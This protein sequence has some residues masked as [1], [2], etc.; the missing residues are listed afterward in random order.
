MSPN[1]LHVVGERFTGFASENPEVITLPEL[2]RLL[3]EQGLPGDTTLIVGQG[4]PDERLRRLQ[5]HLERLPERMR[6][7]LVADP[8]A[9]SR[10]EARLVHKRS[11]HNIMI[12]APEQV[13]EG[14]RYVSSLV[15]DERCAEMSDHQT[16]QHIQGMV[17]ME[18]A[19]QMI[20]AVTERYFLRDSGQRP[21]YF[22]LNQLEATYHS[23]GFP[24]GMDVEYHGVRRKE[25][26]GGSLTCEAKVCFVQGGELLT[27]VT[28]RFA[29]YDA[30]FLSSREAKK[31]RQALARATPLM[32][33]AG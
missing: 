28:I 3:Q 30:A 17:L 32:R 9:L 21:S 29:V 6:A 15:L 20:L 5:A 1:V 24:L 23:F 10:A 8:R 33:K 12:T 4:I 11:E 19:R 13:V 25:S 22:V 14:E 16:G 27:E 31:A 2:E 26:K 18:A 7:T